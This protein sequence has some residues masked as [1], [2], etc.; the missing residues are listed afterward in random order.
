VYFDVEVMDLFLNNLSGTLLLEQWDSQG[1]SFNS[2]GAD[3]S[4]K[5]KK[6][7]KEARISIGTNYS[8]YKYDYYTELGVQEHVRTWYLTGKYPLNKG[9]SVNGTYE[10]EQSFETFQ[11][12]R[13]GMRYDF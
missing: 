1:Q 6:N 10:Y 4:Y 12:L 11:T 7:K 3:L 13:L 9:F 5:I 8:L 2:I